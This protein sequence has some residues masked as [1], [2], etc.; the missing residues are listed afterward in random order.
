MSDHSTWR[1]VSDWYNQFASHAQRPPETEDLGNGRHLPVPSWDPFEDPQDSESESSWAAVLAAEAIRVHALCIR[2]R[3]EC[4]EMDRAF[5]ALRQA[6]EN[7]FLDAGDADRLCRKAFRM[8]RKA[9][10][11]ALARNEARLEQLEM[12]LLPYGIGVRRR[13]AAERRQLA[14]RLDP[15][16]RSLHG[17]T[18]SKGSA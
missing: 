4:E 1:R 15:R 3:A 7:G 5:E 10:K 11:S 9:A 2:R 8:S 13:E 17:K 16:P 6:S 18:L 12:E 14:A